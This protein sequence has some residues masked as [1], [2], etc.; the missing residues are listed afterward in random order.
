MPFFL[1]KD[2]WQHVCYVLNY[3][4]S[5]DTRKMPFSKE[6]VKRLEYGWGE[7]SDIVV[8]DLNV[9]DE[10]VPE[11]FLDQPQ[12]NSKIQN[13]ERIITRL[14]CIKLKHSTKVQLKRLENWPPKT[15]NIP[16]KRLAQK[17]KTN[18]A[19]GEG[20]S[21]TEVVDI[22]SNNGKL[23][24]SANHDSLDDLFEYY[25]NTIMIEESP[26]N[27]KPSIPTDK[28]HPVFLSPRDTNDLDDS[29]I[30]SSY[31]VNLS[32]IRAS[33]ASPYHLYLKNLNIRLIRI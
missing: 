10:I 3:T 31:P 21:K 20:S 32:P 15:I 4:L 27:S 24:D 19:D 12:N 1:K 6:R 25:L 14:K 7:I 11:Y 9:Q 18:N 29:D 33:K 22:S 17:P 16:K 8:L 26:I 13:L 2:K 28:S 5:F 23:V 30:C